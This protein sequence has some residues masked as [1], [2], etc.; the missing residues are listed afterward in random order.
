M[1]NRLK[2]AFGTSACFALDMNKRSL[3]TTY[4]KN[5]WRDRT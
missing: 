5:T 2:K 1:Q 4:F 3:T